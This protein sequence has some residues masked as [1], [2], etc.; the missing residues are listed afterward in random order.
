MIWTKSHRVSLL[1]FIRI[2]SLTVRPCERAV[3]F[4]N[5]IPAAGLASRR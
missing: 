4:G 2:P 5:T 1:V 3:S